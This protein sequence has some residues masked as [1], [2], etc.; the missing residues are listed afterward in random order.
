VAVSFAAYEAATVFAPL[1]IAL[2]AIGIVWPLQHWLQARMPKLIA[3]AI[4]HGSS[5]PISNF[6]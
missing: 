2:F 4:P 3:L 6:R 1:A 5:F